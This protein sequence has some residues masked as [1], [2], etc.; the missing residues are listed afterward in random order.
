MIYEII[1]VFMISDNS[2]V[3]EIVHIAIDVSANLLG[4]EMIIDAT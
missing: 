1:N 4:I 3:I 2:F